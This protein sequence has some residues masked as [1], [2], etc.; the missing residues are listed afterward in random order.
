MEKIKKMRNPNK[1][2]VLLA[3]VGVS[4]ILGILYVWSVISKG[5]MNEFHWSSTQA[6][7]PYSIFT[8][9]MALGF[10]TAGRI[11]DKTGPRICI[12]ATSILMGAGLIISGLFTTPWLVAIGFG[13]V[14]GV[15]V[16]TGNVSSLAPA[17]KWFPAK[18][19]GMV[20]GTVLAGIGLSA[21]IYAPLSNVLI[22]AIGTSKTFLIYGVIS[23]VLMYLLS[24]FMVNPPKGYDPETGL[25]AEQTNETIKSKESVSNSVKT[26]RDFSTKEMVKTIDFYKLF[27]LLA[28]S[29][30]SGLM[31]IGHAAKIAQTQ[32]SW[33]G[34][35]LLVII[36]SLFNTMGRFLGGSIS[37]IIGR[38]N[39]MKLIFLVQ[40]VNMLCFGLYTTIPTLI[41]GIMVAGFCYGTIFSVFPSITAD[42]YGLKNFG[43]N[44]GSIF[45]AWGIGGII[46]PMTAAKI[47]DA[48][49]GYNSAYIVA[50]VLT[51][52]ALAISFTFKK[53][54]ELKKD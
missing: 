46:G 6:S 26:T 20:S 19:K 8:V 14:C 36:L 22:G 49:G 13:V 29:S 37:D 12:V 1:W 21:V 27:I 25:V 31:I 28:L 32:A 33:Q 15:G 51:V 43:A 24:R 40:A 11:Q 30:S 54:T 18:K 9:F 45:L 10:F 3:A 34:G 17:L 42:F 16:G 35:F 39:T 2:S 4:I 38:I 5:L 52:L 44:Y 50:C 23:L 41:I 47:M 53:K 7:L 48:T